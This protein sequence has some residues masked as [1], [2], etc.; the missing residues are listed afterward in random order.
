[1]LA[2]HSLHYEQKHFAGAFRLTSRPR[3]A[4]RGT[5]GG[6]FLQLI[7]GQTCHPTESRL[8]TRKIVT[9]LYGIKGLGK[10]GER[11]NSQER[12]TGWF[13]YSQLCCL[14]SG[15]GPRL[16]LRDEFQ[17]SAFLRAQTAV[18]GSCPAGFGIYGRWLPAACP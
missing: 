5:R 3:P 11:T 16:I 13:L 1:M 8:F 12:P 18:G 7:L 17:G 9:A 4:K 6:T 10:A 14:F 15:H 2:R